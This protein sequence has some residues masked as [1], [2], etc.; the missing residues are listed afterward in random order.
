LRN[1]QSRL[2]IFLEIYSSQIM[3]HGYAPSGIGDHSRFCL[4][5]VDPFQGRIQDVKL[6]GA[7]KKNCAER[8]EARKFLGYFVWKIT[9]LRQKI[10]FFSILGGRAPGAPPLLFG[11]LCSQALK[12]VGF[13]IIWPWEYLMKL[14]PEIRHAH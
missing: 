2:D 10:L 7:L 1:K 6:G 14:V 8:R 3:Y 5:C 13:Q 11:F 12:S 4:S 9:I